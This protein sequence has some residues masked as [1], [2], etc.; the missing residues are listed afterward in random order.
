MGMLTWTLQFSFEFEGNQAISKDLKFYTLNLSNQTLFPN[1]ISSFLVQIWTIFMVMG[2]QY[3]FELKRQ[4]SYVKGFKLTE[5]L[6]VQTL[7]CLPHQFQLWW[8]LK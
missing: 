4:L 2:P 7:A 3:F 8:H 5:S 1:S 6:N